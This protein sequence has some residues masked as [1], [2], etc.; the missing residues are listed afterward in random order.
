MLSLVVDKV[1]IERV[2]PEKAMTA[3]D[4]FRAQFRVLKDLEKK[5]TIKIAASFVHPPGGFAVIETETHEELLRIL[6]T[7]PANLYT[8]RD[9]YPLVSN[10][11]I[12]NSLWPEIEA[13]FKAMPT[14]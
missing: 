6:A 11:F 2:A 14:K 9:V 5:G 1:A 7:L 13:Q 10:D 8:N 12:A 3:L 4:M